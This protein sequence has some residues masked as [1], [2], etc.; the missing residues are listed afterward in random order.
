VIGSCA[1]TWPQKQKNR[2]RAV[3][4]VFVQVCL[5]QQRTEEI[6]QI[7]REVSTHAVGTD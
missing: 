2:Q 4:L 7:F 3:L 5:Y 1:G 6:F